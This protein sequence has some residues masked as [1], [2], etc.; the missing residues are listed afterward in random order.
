MSAIAQELDATLAELDEASAAA[1]E[2]LVRDAVELAKARRRAA[3]PL[4]ELGWP[5]GFFEKYAGSLEGDDWEEA[6]DPPPAPS[7]EPA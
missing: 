5:T 3:G 1:L 6:E 2:R 4:D 7:L